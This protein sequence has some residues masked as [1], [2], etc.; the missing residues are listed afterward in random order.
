[1]PDAGPAGL[2]AAIRTEHHDDHDRIVFQFH[3]PA[4][5]EPT[6]GY[7]DHVTTDPANR[8]VALQGKA[9]LT[10]VFHGARLDT[11][12][13]ES[14]PSRA[15]RY[16]G[17]DRL[18]PGYPLLRELAIA[19][20][21]EAVL[22][23]G[24]G[25][26][27]VAGLSESRPAGSGSVVLDIW[28]TAPRTLLWPMTTVAQAEEVQRATE[29]GHQPWTL[30]AEQV[31]QSYAQSVLGWPQATVRRLSERVYEVRAPGKRAILTLTQP[32]GRP[33]T[34]WAVSSVVH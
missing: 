18:S 11:T 9:Y 22:S 6:I 33:H 12:P 5:P 20:D 3:G 7:V 14:D 29:N 4:A 23:F 8:P 19:G 28:P 34:V 25:L 17:P 16:A 30:S 32:L 10:V 31:A 26:S 21:F 1:L 2:L 13:V 27:G 15:R 24:I